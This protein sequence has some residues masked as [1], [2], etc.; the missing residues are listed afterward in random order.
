MFLRRRLIM[1]H[2]RSLNSQPNYLKRGVVVNQRAAHHVEHPAGPTFD[3]GVAKMRLLAGAEQT[4]KAFGL[5]EFAGSAG[6]W[7]VTHLHQATQESFFVVRGSFTFT[8]DGDSIHAQV[9]DYVLVP[10]KTPHSFEA[11][12]DGGTLL[13]LFVP[14]GLEEMFIETLRTYA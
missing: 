12:P 5:A 9:G 6:P 8:I 14:G 13:A 1:A 10:P 3:L 11:G 2:T 7:T 4:E